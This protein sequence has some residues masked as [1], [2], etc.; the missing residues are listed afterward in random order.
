[1]SILKKTGIV[2]LIG[3]TVLAGGFAIVLATAPLWGENPERVIHD[4]NSIIHYAI[5]VS[6][7]DTTIKWVVPAFEDI[8]QC[9]D[10]ELLNIAI[11]C[12]V[13]QSVGDVNDFIYFGDKLLPKRFKIEGAKKE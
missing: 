6:H 12:S 4:S 3:F 5:D 8:K 10:E 9:T 2:F 1:M 7:T 13:G 11:F